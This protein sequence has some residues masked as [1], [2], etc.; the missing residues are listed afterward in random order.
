MIL[1]LRVN[2][3]PLPLKQL[4]L[5]RAA[6][7]AELSLQIVGMHALSVGAAV[8]LQISDGSSLAGV[9]TDASSNGHITTVSASVAPA[10][11]SS[12]FA[13]AT[14]QF[15]SSGAVRAAL[16]FAVLPGDTYQ[17]RAIAE[18]TATLGTDSP[19]FTEIRF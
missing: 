13:P 14:L 15:I 9:V 12:V 3:Q 6:D 1:L 11:G 5:R 2:D 16:D 8:D 4:T 18:V 19:A 7:A 17:G 10:L